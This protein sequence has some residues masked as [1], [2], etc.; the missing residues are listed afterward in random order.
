[1]PR[2]LRFLSIAVIACAALDAA[3]PARADV[4]ALLACA[5]Q[6][7]PKLRLACYDSEAAKLKTQLVEAEAKKNTLFGFTLPFGG[8]EQEAGQP[9]E[10]KFGPPEVNEVDSKLSGVTKDITGHYIVTLDNG[11]F[12]RIEDSVNF[13]LRAAEQ[14]VAV[15]RNGFGGFYL[16]IDGHDNKLSVTRLK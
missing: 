4:P 1:M 2:F 15:A 10:P 14:P 6:A 9:P 5:D 8:S 16:G 12:W 3:P 7:D 13:Y 11:Q